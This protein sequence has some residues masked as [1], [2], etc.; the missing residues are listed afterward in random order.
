MPEKISSVNQPFSLDGFN[1]TKANEE[2]I[3]F[4]FSKCDCLAQNED[5]NIFMI[6][7]S[8]HERFHCL[9]LPSLYKCLPQIL[10]KEALNLGISS[11]LLNGSVEQRAGFNSLCGYASVNHL[12][13]HTYYLNQ[14]MKLETIVVKHLIG[15]CFVLENYPAKAFVFQVT[16]KGELNEIVNDIYLLVNLF[17]QKNVAHN[18]FI[19]RG[20]GFERSKGSKETSERDC[21]RIYVW[22]RT[23]SFGYKTLDEFN[24]A[25]CELFG[26]LIVKTSKA[27]EELTETR[28]AEILYSIT[29]EPYSSVKECVKDLY[30][31]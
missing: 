16:T 5:K 14:P 27:Y 21:V 2:E 8:P 3:M 31:R 20:L 13:L 25:I 9:L 6:N 30:K 19:T 4:S 26:H 11:V 15:N 24:P 18:L 29:H 10:N 7:V 23:S 12:H 28:V 1:F 17:I 22:A